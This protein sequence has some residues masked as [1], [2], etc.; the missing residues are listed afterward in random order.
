VFFLVYTLNL[1]GDHGLEPWTS[2]LSDLRSNQ[3]S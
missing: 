2:D 3:L 1:V